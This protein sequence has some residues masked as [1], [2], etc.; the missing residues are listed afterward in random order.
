MYLTKCFDNQLHI[1]ENC[2]NAKQ[3][4]FIDNLMKELENIFSFLDQIIPE[5]VKTT[6][7]RV[8]QEKTEQ[9]DKLFTLF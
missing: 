8:K 1:L 3:Y 9:D 2:I 7:E 4:K 6:Y 5:K